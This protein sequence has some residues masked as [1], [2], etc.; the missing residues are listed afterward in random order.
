MKNLPISRRLGIVVSVILLFG[1]ASVTVLSNL[2]MSKSLKTTTYHRMQENADNRKAM[3]EDYIANTEQYLKAFAQGGDLKNCLKNPT[4]ENVEVAQ[5][6]TDEYYNVHGALENLYLCTTESEVITS[7]VR[8]SIGVHFREGDALKELQNILFSSNEVYN[9][10]TMASKST[11]LQVM[12]MYCPVYDGDTPLGYVGMAVMADDLL[13]ILQELEFVDLE[14][15]YYEILDINQRKYIS[16]EDTEK[17]G[18]PI[19]EPEVL[20]RIE[21]VNLDDIKSFYQKEYKNSETNKTEISIGC[22]IPKRG[23]IINIIVGKSVFNKAITELSMKLLV[24][25]TIV[26]F[27]TVAVVWLLASWVSKDF[28]ALGNIIGEL[29]KL[30][31]G[32][33]KKLEPFIH[34][35]DEVGIMANAMLLLVSTIQGTIQK[36]QSQSN[37]LN[38]ASVSLEKV[39]SSNM[40]HMTLFENTIHDIASGVGHQAS[41]TERAAL[42]I[43]NIGDMVEAMVG[44]AELLEENS[45]ALQKANE[46]GVETFE[47]LKKVNVST[48]SSVQKIFEQ[49]NTTNM[50]VV[51]I[52]KAVSFIS[53]I[54]N[55]TS[56]LSL[57]ASIEAARAG[58]QGK[59]FAVVATQIKQLAEQSNKAA[60][61]IT[62]IITNLIQ[63]SEVSVQIVNEVKSNIVQ[64]SEQV[65]DTMQIFGDMKKRA[66]VSTNKIE[67]IRKEIE[68]MNHSKDEVVGVVHNLAAISEENAASVEETASSIT[69]VTE[70]MKSVQDA[71]N[72]LTEIVESLN[73]SIYSFKLKE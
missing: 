44:E 33:K 11:G 42:N 58:E 10:G 60:S 34:R 63:E 26:L 37:K 39:F 62:Q 69:E 3:I 59:G 35:K 25:C 12:S 57:N 65:N 36:L 21:Q 19:T 5:R 4:P 71:A 8:S 16:C 29:G 27:I 31:L 70:E 18:T 52:Q 22:V 30:E 41:E 45:L 6:Y 23:W 24:I 51:E 43:K 40:E 7:V 61:E 73:A 64:Q 67:C 38:E 68:S 46:A 28:K 2:V 9:I 72:T 54:A 15:A 50:S 13:N 1:L 55:E 49:T 32:Q 20:S 47:K 56:L 53:E 48:E 66:D 14:N 17:N